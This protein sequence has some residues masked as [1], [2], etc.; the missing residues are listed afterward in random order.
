MDLSDTGSVV[1]KENQASYKIPVKV[2][3]KKKNIK[4]ISDKNSKIRQIWHS[5]ILGFDRIFKLFFFSKNGLINL[6][7]P[8][9][10]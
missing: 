2:I 1:N 7:Q 5:Y 3:K 9:I 6:L 10:W 4:K 8:M